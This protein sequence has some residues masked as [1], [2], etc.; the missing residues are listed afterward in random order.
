MDVTGNRLHPRTLALPALLLVCWCTV[1][2]CSSLRL[3]R[4]D[5]NGASIFLP[6]PNSTTLV[7]P[8]DRPL[9]ALVERHRA[10]GC[11][12]G[13]GCGSGKGC[14]LRPDPAFTT[15]IEPGTCD[16]SNRERFQVRSAER[17]NSM[18]NNRPGREGRGGAD[19]R[20]GQELPSD[21]VASQSRFR[22]GSCQC[23]WVQGR[24]H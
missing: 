10:S 1:A 23:R 9:A 2:G 18:L 13:L 24:S 15:P 22:T 6:A 17:L 20:G 4:I 3:P 7:G 12:L 8:A 16:P 21:A 14:G 11:K 19:G 5:P